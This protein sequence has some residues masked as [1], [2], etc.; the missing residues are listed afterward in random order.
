[1]N[2]HPT[3]TP[4]L[5]DLL[6]LALWLALLLAVFVRLER[7]GALRP[8]RLLRTGWAQDLGHFFLSG[9][10]PKLLLS[11]P[12]TLL[13]AA[14]HRG[15]PSPY[16][17]AVAELPAG[18]RLVLAMAVGEVG[19][20][21]GH[22]ACHRWPLLW[23]FHAVHHRAEKLDWLVNTRAHPVDLVFTRLC[24]LVP[25]YVLGLAQP[26]AQG[27][28]TVPLW[29][30][31]AGTCWSFFIH[32][33]LRW[34]LGPLEALLSTPAFHHWHHAGAEAGVPAAPC[35]FALMLPVVD[36]LFGTWHLPAR[37]WPARYGVDAAGPATVQPRGATVTAIRP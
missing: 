34:R 19:A 37:A 10:V 4:L 14:L 5:Q 20:Y 28:D 22:R 36:R 32:A 27:V 23:R 17:A 15:L 25:L 11:L 2:H 13:A 1:M 33:N 6:R 16:Y 12:L 26:V 24:A 9:L 8:Q 7:Y 30:T 31:V 18:L 29:F 21:W 3:L 35:N